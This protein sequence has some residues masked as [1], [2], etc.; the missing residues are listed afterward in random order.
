MI[1][2][3][4]EHYLRGSL[5]VVGCVAYVRVMSDCMGAVGRLRS[6][7]RAVRTGVLLYI[8]VLSL[9][10]C[11]Q[12][13]TPISETAATATISAVSTPP[14]AA[15][16]KPAN[17]VRTSIGFRSKHY[18]DEHFAKH[19]SEFRGMSKAEYL[20]AAQT[21]RDSPV[22]GSVEEIVRDDGTASRFDRESGAFIA[23]NRDGTIRTFFKPN[24]GERYF[25]RQA[26]R[27][28]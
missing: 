18:L 23:F 12:G 26:Q 11:R 16:A 7:A 27:S 6:L 3:V 10:G 8:S 15:E 9:A 17:A 24:D 20:L 21:L 19:G 2:P 14:Q 5:A 28:H 1:H 4:S 22:G 13:D 25:R